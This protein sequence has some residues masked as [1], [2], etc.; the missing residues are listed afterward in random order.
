MS[1]RNR[2]FNSGKKTK[3]N[4][5]RKRI[6]KGDKRGPVVQWTEETWLG[7][8]QDRAALEQCAVF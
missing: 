7:C 3:Q 6:T 1:L 8:E 2:T 4:S 5:K